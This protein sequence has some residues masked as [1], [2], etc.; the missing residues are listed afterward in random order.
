MRTAPD[1]RNATWRKSS[2]SGGNSAE[3]VEV[4]DDLPGLVPVRDSKNIT[5]GVLVFE[6]A[7][8]SRFVATAP[9]LS[10]W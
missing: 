10:K 8:W 9:E 5:G 1:L 2:Y 6:A 4:S 7:A 3:C